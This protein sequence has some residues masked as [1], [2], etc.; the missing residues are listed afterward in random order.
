MGSG[1]MSISAFARRSLLS[2]K[3]LRLYDEMGLLRPNRIDPSS[4]YRYY[5]ES[6]L[7]TARLISLLRKLDVPLVEIAQIVPLAPKDAAEALATWWQKELARFE[8]RADLLQ[9]IQGSVLGVSS[10][11]SLPA[12]VY[13]IE[14]RE[15]PE[16]TY[17]YRTSHVH[18][19]Q[20]PVFIGNSN[21]ALIERAGTYGGAQGY[22]TVVFHGVVDLD[23]DGPADV[24]VPIAAGSVAMGDD[25]IRTEATHLQAYTVLRKH[26]VEFPQILQV[27][28][29]LRHWFEANGYARS[30]PPREIYL[31][32]FVAAESN[33]LICE[34]AFP[35]Q[36]V[37]GS[38]S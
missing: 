28:Q 16:T 4:R 5:S 31:G 36:P 7:E 37:K 35:I 1:D 8:T 15:V 13:A 6:Q 26:Q 24:C 32:N 9:Y 29:S 34:V 21:D 3:A 2:V 22:C 12:D 27:Y 17:L 33:D 20:L 18:G 23:S 19:P 38:T 30:G 25:L 11:H 14:V 10:G